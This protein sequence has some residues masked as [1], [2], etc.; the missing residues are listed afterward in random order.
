M[1]NVTRLQRDLGAIVGEANALTGDAVPARHTQDLW[2]SDLV[3]H[4]ALVVRPRTATELAEVLKHCNGIGQPVVVQGGMTGLVSGGVPNEDEVVV[5]TEL[6]SRI[7]AVDPAGRTVTAGAGATLADVQDAAAEHGLLLPID[8]ASKG[9]ATIGGCVATNAG[10]VNVVGFGMTRQHVRS[11]EVALADGRLLTLST[12]LVK[13]N[14]GIDLKQLFIGCE[15]ILGVV[16]SAT[17]GLQPSAITRTGAFCAVSD[18][19]AALRLLHTLQRRLPGAVTAFEVVWDDAYRT[20]EPTGVR[21]PLPFGHPLYVLVECRG[22]DPD[23]DALRFASVM[24]EVQDDVLAAAVAANATELRAFWAARERIPAEILRMQPLFGFDVSVPAGELAKCLREMRFELE[25]S[26]PEVKL[27][28][29]GHL[30]DDNVHIAVITGETTRDRKPEVEHIVYRV[31]TAS[32]GSIS[33]EHGVGFEKRSYLDYT[34]SAGEIALMAQL[35]RTF[36]P[37]GILNRGRMIPWDGRVS[38]AT[39]RGRQGGTD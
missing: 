15:G 26:W 4:A 6:L 3:G 22:S 12:S 36:D 32:G 21:L 37:N 7:S 16:T 28:V 19:D 35:K 33:A 9:S 23:G 39:G 18:V 8:L 30:G 20:L 11:L 17:L 13:D 31:V 10:G 27:L 24:E 1:I 14:A 5:S 2:G 34:R 29:F 25:K 38:C